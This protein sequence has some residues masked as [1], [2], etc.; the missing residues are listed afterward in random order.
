MDLMQLNYFSVIAKHENI[1]KASEELHIP[2]PSLSM[3]LKRL[4]NNL[5]VQLFYRKNG[6]LE[7][8]PYG[9]IMLKHCEIILD[10][11]RKAEKELEDLREN[12]GK[13]ITVG[14]TDWG[15]PLLVFADFMN[16]YPDIKLNSMLITGVKNKDFRDFHCDFV[17]SPLPV[18]YKHSICTILKNE[19]IYLT[20]SNTH[21]LAGYN[22]VALKELEEE[23]LLIAGSN[24]HFG[25]F[26]R[27]LLD[28][29]KIK[30]RES[31]SCT[32]GYLKELLISCGYVALTVSGMDNFMS[33]TDSLVHIPLEP[34]VYRESAVFYGSDAKLSKRKKLFYKFLTNYFL[35][36]E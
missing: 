3:S 16:A 32:A 23:H 5:G 20:C 27:Q 22:Q 34:R 33:G 11:Y 21:R 19:E 9:Q 4:E 6:R 28:S 25:D 7:L 14:I 18:E 8:N 35:L 15:F 13:Q 36:P 1:T 10:E 12:D 30:P 17:I 29:A 24:S 31:E 26:I 2:Q